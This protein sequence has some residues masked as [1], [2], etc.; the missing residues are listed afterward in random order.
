[1][2]DHV[3]RHAKSKAQKLSMCYPSIIFGI[4]VAHK[5]SII[6]NADIYSGPPSKICLLYKLLG[7]QHK[8]DITPSTEAHAIDSSS[9][10]SSLAPPR[11][12]T[13]AAPSSSSS[14]IV[15]YSKFLAFLMEDL[16]ML[17]VQGLSLE[18]LLRSNK[19][20]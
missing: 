7:G 10:D 5:A 6:S 14:P 8:F 3:L 12:G 15:F 13:H 11:V 2:F 17:I 4:L 18:D 16:S 1:M 9:N 20:R 19:E